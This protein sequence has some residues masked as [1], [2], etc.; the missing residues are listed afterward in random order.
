MVLVREDFV[1]KRKSCEDVNPSLISI[2][3]EPFLIMAQSTT[4]DIGRPTTQENVHRVYAVA[5]NSPSVEG[6][7]TLED[8][9]AVLCAFETVS[10]AIEAT[11]NDPSLDLVRHRELSSEEQERV[12]AA[13]LA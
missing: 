4:L 11:S 1:D 7:C 13:L 8:G 10:I 5:R 12:E 6:R 3:E 2:P 9:S